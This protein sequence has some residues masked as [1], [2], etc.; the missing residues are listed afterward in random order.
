MVIDAEMPG[1]AP[2]M[3]PQTRPT[4]DA[5]TSHVV[6]SIMKAR[7]RSSNAQLQNRLIGCSTP[8][9][10]TNSSQNSRPPAHA[11]AASRHDGA[12]PS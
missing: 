2:P 1:S 11:T 3:M 4:I 8:S 12:M 10:T 5:G 6:N 7:A 9:R